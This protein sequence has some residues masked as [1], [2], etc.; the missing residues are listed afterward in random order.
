M[1][2]FI[3][4]FIIWIMGTILA[5]V[6]LGERSTAT[7]IS[8]FFSILGTIGLG[9]AAFVSI[10]DY[11]NNQPKKWE[12]VEV[13]RI[14]RGEEGLSEKE[15]LINYKDKSPYVVYSDDIKY[16]K[17][18]VEESKF[19]EPETKKLATLCGI[20]GKERVRLVIPKK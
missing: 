15:L 1:I 2:L 12:V 4:S 7:R 10:P 6:F 16:P 20:D 13:K 5:L 14:P 9:Y 17:L 11:F 19:K 8:W 3:V 18:Y